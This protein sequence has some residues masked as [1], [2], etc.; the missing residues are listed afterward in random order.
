M[1][2]FSDF[3][4]RNIFNNTCTSMPPDRGLASEKSS[5]VKGKKVRLTYAFTTNADGTEKL[6]PVIIGKSKKPRAFNKKTGEQLGF[7]YRNN[8]KAWMTTTLYQEWLLDWD[9]KLG[10]RKIVLLQDNFSGHVPLNGLRNIEVI[11]FEPNLTSH[12]QPADQGIIHCFK[13]HY[14]LWYIE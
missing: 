11:N 5:G 7:Y 3:T 6:E 2:K 13:A 9:Q 4:P 1:R 12:V 8:A 10:D 14:R